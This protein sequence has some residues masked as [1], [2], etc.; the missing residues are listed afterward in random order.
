VQVT[1]V[2]YKLVE[3][4]CTN[5]WDIKHVNYSCIRNKLYWLLHAPMSAS[6]CHAES[7]YAECHYTECRCAFGVVPM[8]IE[9][10]PAVNPIQLFTDVIYEF[11]K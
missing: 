1:S 7:R 10:I 9:L 4:Y 3:L 8:S 6:Y 2:S 11:S 5:L